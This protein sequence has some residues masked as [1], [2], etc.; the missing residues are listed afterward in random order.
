MNCYERTQKQKS[1]LVTAYHLEA[2]P[3]GTQVHNIELHPGKGGQMVRS[4]GNAHSSWLKKESMQ[5]FDFH[6]EK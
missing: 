2:I 6:Q 3:V 1:R 4:A 5:H